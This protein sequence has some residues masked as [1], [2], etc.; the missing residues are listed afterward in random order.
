MV[1]YLEEPGSR[2]CNRPLISV[3]ANRSFTVRWLLNFARSLLHF[4]GE[5]V[6]REHFKAIRR[7]AREVARDLDTTDVI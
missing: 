3:M 7:R 2:R 4:L 6:D 5:L 1:G